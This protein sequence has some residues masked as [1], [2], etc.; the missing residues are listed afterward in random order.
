[1]NKNQKRSRET[2]NL[3]LSTAELC[4][5]RTGYDG[6]SVSRICQE[7][8]VSKGAFYHHFD[9]KQAVFLALLERWLANM[10]K[11]IT[12]LIDDAPDVP[13]KLLGMANIIG[14]LLKVPND[15]L[16]I[17]QEYL[18]QA[19]RAPELWHKTIQPYY[20]YRETLTALVSEGVKEGDLGINDPKTAAIM[21]MAMAL[22]LLIQGFLDPEGADW[23]LVTQQS[24]GFLVAG[25]KPST[26][27]P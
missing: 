13:D 20:Q 23:A 12:D 5:G 11:E 10:D 3:I 22:G 19:V 9:S 8:D 25:L 1:M 16:L 7:A 15:Q 21:I 6:T 2:R 14:Q 27:D 18:N 17:Y 24:M 4:F 26:G